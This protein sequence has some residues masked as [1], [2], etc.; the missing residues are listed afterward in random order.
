MRYATPTSWRMICPSRIGLQVVDVA[1]LEPREDGEAQEQ[2]AGRPGER[3]GHRGQGGKPAV[4]DGIADQWDQVAQRIDAQLE[5]E[6]LEPPRPVLAE[7]LQIVEHGR[8]V[9]ENLQQ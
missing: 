6:E 8:Q 3:H 1:R 7:L 2:R 9:E 5:P 4:I